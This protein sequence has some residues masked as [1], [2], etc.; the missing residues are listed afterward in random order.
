MSR[1]LKIFSL[2]ILLGLVVGCT[3][4]VTLNP[5][6]DVSASIS[7]KLDL[8]VGL[9]IPPEVK[10]FKTADNATWA[11]KY[12]FNMGEAISSIINKACLR[13]FT[14]VE[15]LET[16]PT[17]QMFVERKL[18]LALTARI[19]EGKV[20][21]NVQDGFFS[22]DAKGTTQI[23]IN[24]NVIDPKL[25]Q[26]ASIQATG[27]GTGDE[28]IGAFSSGK[29]EFSAAVEAAIRNL[30]NDIVQQLYGNYDLRKLVEA[31]E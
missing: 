16:N 13:V 22:S 31:K 14:S 30:G 18:D 29:D 8:K 12:E 7:N 23:S 11:H 20:S 26:I 19:T 21:L 15:L 6:I 17:E 3:H 27:I 2:F 24:L 5:N 4:S 10:Y 9:Y 25:L 28:T 1:I